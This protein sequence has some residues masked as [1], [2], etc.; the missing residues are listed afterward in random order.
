MPIPRILLERT[1]DFR[2]LSCM[3]TKSARLHIAALLRLLFLLLISAIAIRS[4]KNCSMDRSGP[5]KDAEKFSTI[6]RGGQTQV[7]TNVTEMFYQ[8]NLP[9][10]RDFRS[11][12]R[13]R[14]AESR[15][16]SDV[17]HSVLFCP[18]QFA[19]LLVRLYQLRREAWMLKARKV[20]ARSLRLESK[21]SIILTVR[22][23]Q[24]TVATP[25]RQCKLSI[26]R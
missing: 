10:E 5:R 9:G 17:P 18:D 8:T 25:A 22:L 7:D 15:D 23:N 24:P 12:R 21:D 6:L 19:R 2:R 11:A 14:R 4:N 3:S 20:C 26:A 16:K 1:L 13:G